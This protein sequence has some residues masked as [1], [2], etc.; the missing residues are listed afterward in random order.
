MGKLHYFHTQIN[1][2]Q[3]VCQN[4][5]LI[6]ILVGLRPL[7]P[8][9]VAFPLFIIIN[10]YPV[11]DIAF[12]DTGK[13]IIE[14]GDVGDGLLKGILVLFDDNEKGSEDGGRT[15]DVT[16]LG[17]RDLT[18]ETLLQL[19]LKSENKRIARSFNHSQ[20]VHKEKGEVLVLK[21]SSRAKK[22]DAPFYT[23][24][25]NEFLFFFFFIKFPQNYYKFFLIPN[26]T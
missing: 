7:N 10:T 4:E 18:D 8:S 17:I 21:V 11:G 19:S 12:L 13:G 9:S 26:L 22:E 23:R 3:I 24:K 1:T 5:D 25:L 14:L 16:G 20:R 2:V 15:G 6:F